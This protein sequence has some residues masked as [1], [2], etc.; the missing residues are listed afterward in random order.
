VKHHFASIFAACIS[1][2]C[3]NK[4]SDQEK[5]AAVL[6]GSLLYITKMSADERDTLIKKQMVCINP[7]HSFYNFIMATSLL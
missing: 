4:K 1:L 5:A 2:H 7:L 6:Q 3:G